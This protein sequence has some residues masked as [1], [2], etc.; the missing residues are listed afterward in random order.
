MKDEPFA[1]PGGEPKAEAVSGCDG[2]HNFVHRLSRHDLLAAYLPPLC[3]K[4]KVTDHVLNMSIESGSRRDRV[5]VPQCKSDAA[6]VCRKIRGGAGRMFQENGIPGNGSRHAR[7]A[8]N[9]SLYPVMPIRI[10]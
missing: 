10:E 8:Q 2:L 7:R 9:H 5:G 4:A 6:L 3:Q 1:A